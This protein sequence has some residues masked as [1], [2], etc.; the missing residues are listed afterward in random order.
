MDVYSDVSFLTHRVVSRVRFYRPFVVA[1]ELRS[2]E[3]ESCEEY[4][5]APYR[6]DRFK[7]IHYI[8]TY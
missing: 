2:R 4:Y 1:V 5:V 6:F 7:N 8:T 3:S